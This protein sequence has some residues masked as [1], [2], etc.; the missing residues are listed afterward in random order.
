[1]STDA[2][3]VYV[4][5]P[6]RGTPPLA[7]GIDPKSGIVGRRTQPEDPESPVLI[8]Y[9]GNRFGYANVITFADRCMIAAGR[10]VEDAPTI[11]KMLVGHD[12]V[13]R[14]ASYLPEYR[15]VELDDQLG[16]TRLAAWLQQGHFAGGLFVPELDGNDL[17][18]SH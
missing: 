4:P 11:A 7:F 6:D 3:D 16:V 9:E 1:M 13:I 2:I 17:L 12:A 10:M 15:R 18:C 5:N 14:V 8:Y